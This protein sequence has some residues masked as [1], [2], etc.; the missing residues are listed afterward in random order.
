MLQ[1]CP[2]QIGALQVGA[3]QIGSLQ[4][5]MREISVRPDLYSVDN[6]D[7]KLL[8]RTTRFELATLTLAR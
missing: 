1:I 8:E 3:P 5:G 7:S 6:H 4:I 2:T